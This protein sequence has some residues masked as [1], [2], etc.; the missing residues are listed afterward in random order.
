[1]RPIDADSLIE[2]LELL[3]KHEESFRQSVILG[4]IHAVKAR[5]TIDAVPVVR[6][7]N[8]KYFETQLCENEDNYDNWFCA[9]GERKDE[10]NE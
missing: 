4:V 2:D 9:D 6:C 10:A 8:C 5:S 7:K 1:M 3:A